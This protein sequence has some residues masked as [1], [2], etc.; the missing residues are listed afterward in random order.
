MRTRARGIGGGLA[1]AVLALAPAAGLAQSLVVVRDDGGG[2]VGGAEIYRDCTRLG[3]TSGAGML[4]VPTLS[5]GDHLQVRKLVQTGASAKGG[6]DGWSYH[7]WRTNITMADD[8]RQ[9]DFI[10]SDPRADQNVV[11]RR[12]NTQIGWNLLGSLEYN[13]T[14]ANLDEIARALESASGY[15]FDVSDGQFFIEQATLYEE[16]EHWADADIQFFANMW[17]NATGSVGAAAV[18]ASSSNHMY[19]PGPG[20]D[21]N[22]YT[23]GSWPTAFGFRTIVHEQG[24]YGLGLWDEYTHRGGATSCTLDRASVPEVRRA[25][26]M[27]SQYDASELCHDGNHNPVTWQGEITG[28]SSW[29]AVA[30]NWAGSAWTF[31]TPMT[32]GGVVNP[33]PD[34][35]PC[36][37]RMTTRVVPVAAE[38]CAPLRLVARTTSGDPITNVGVDLVHGARRI[39][40]GNTDLTGQNPIYGA[41][42]GDRISLRPPRPVGWGEF[43]RWTAGDATVASACGRVEMET[44]LE[45][46]PRIID[47]RWETV[48]FIHQGDPA[49]DV[50][51]A[52]PVLDP[53]T[54]VQVV[55]EQ[56]GER[57]QVVP[58]TYDPGQKAFVGT[59]EVDPKRALDF[60]L[61]LTAKGP[62]GARVET[63]ARLHGAAYEAQGPGA[64]WP[65]LS[66]DA[67]VTL[68]VDGST[69][70]DGTGVLVSD[71]LLPAADPAFLVSGSS[72]VTVAG[73]RPLLKAAPLT[74]RFD[75]G[76]LAEGTEQ[77]YQLI[78]DEWVAL[79]TSVDRETSRATADVDSWG[80]FAV[81]GKPVS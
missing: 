80:T 34:A 23:P 10:V 52:I 28:L 15:L 35:L 7:A 73:E 31:R 14:T 68:D 44:D 21:G 49:P 4:I 78:G 2:L 67:D 38:A 6:H 51:V 30:A 9:V 40:Q 37:G 3:V 42:P 27:S 16:R 62:K 59:Y 53:A 45:C 56:D 60:E 22:N 79:P 81:F 11:I 77:V 74:L 8:G 63:A 24:H 17:P 64:S 13:A 32:R 5:P 47:R 58:L 43:C 61:E 26:I 71:A 20:F 12:Q 41:Q 65:L 25:S 19:L 75:R 33:G 50:L 70:P 48:R 1:L 72:A 46:F 69:L 36:F 18:L 54:L 66:A 57:R 55:L 29:A 76:R 39:F